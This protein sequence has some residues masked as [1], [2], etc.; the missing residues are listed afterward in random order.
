MRRGGSPS[1][2]PV[3]ALRV[4]SR[5]AVSQAH[6]LDLHQVIADLH[7]KRPI[8]VT[9]GVG[10]YE[11]LGVRQKGVFVLSD[12]RVPLNGYPREKDVL[13]VHLALGYSVVTPK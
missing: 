8:Y 9:D 4:R 6:R 5:A 13:G 3:P 10:L 11:I 2:P 7:A 12:C 1:F